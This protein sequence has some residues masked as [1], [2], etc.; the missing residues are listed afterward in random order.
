[1]VIIENNYS[2]KANCKFCDIE[3]SSQEHLVNCI[4]IKGTNNEVLFNPIHDLIQNND[5]YS[6]DM[7]QMKKTATFFRDAI[8]ANEVL[9]EFYC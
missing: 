2:G 1:M 5:I 8:R 9:L 4:F 6:N 3:P 7:L